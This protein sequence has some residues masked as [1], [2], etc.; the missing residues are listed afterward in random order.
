M[1][2]SQAE[3]FFILTRK[4]PD[5][6]PVKYHISDRRNSIRFIDFDSHQPLEPWIMKYE[7]LN[8]FDSYL[9]LFFIPYRIQECWFWIIF[10]RFN[11][12]KRPLFYFKVISMLKIEE[13]VY[14]FSIQEKKRPRITSKIPWWLLSIFNRYTT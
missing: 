8:V 4:A 10:Y 11:A 2:L 14:F 5:V 3:C 13:N 9:M 1:V 6:P 12:I 7:S